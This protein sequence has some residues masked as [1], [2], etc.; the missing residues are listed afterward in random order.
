MAL[1]HN[2]QVKEISGKEFFKFSNRFILGTLVFTFLIASQ[3][4]VK[5]EIDLVG[6]DRGGVIFCEVDLVDNLLQRGKV[7]LNGLIH[8]YISVG[9]IQDLA[10]HAALQQP[11]H[12]LKGRVGLSCAG[13][14]NQQ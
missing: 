9:K 1:V 11:V 14:H 8:Q 13:G 3:L 4:L 5:G 2:Y 10:F 6:C 7:L 12:N